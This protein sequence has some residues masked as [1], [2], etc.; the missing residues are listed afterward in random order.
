MNKT[1]NTKQ[2][3]CEHAKRLFNEKGYTQ[4][5]LRDIAD[6]AGTTIGNLTHHFPQKRNL[7]EAIQL[8]LH[9]TFSDDFFLH[10]S[11]DA[12]LLILYRS[13]LTAQKYRDNYPFYYRYVHELCKDSKL[14]AQNSE[15]FRKKLFDYYIK[16]FFQLKKVGQMRSD[17]TNKQYKSLAYTIIIV[18]TAWTQNA[19]PYYDDALPKMNL[20]EALED[21][22][23]PYLTNSGIDKWKII[24]SS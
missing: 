19:S 15:K 16:T 23:F 12:P 3:I 7:I 1:S 22:I 11:E 6:A 14:M 4:V 18:S 17:I 24:S 20:S 13:F 9:T 21:M 2:L 10:S 8:D 5:S